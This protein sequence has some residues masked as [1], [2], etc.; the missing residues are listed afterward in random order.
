MDIRTTLPL[1]LLCALP[2]FARERIPVAGW[3]VADAGS[4]VA[5]ATDKGWLTEDND[6]LLLAGMCVI[7]HPTV[8]KGGLKSGIYWGESYL[9][10]EDGCECLMPESMQG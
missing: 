10:T 9:V 3:R 7:I 8:L 6:R 1:G 5:E 2:S 4:V